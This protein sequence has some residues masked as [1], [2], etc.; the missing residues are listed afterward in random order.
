M[1]DGAGR[2]WWLEAAADGGRAAAPQ[3]PRQRPATGPRLAV[4]ILLL[5]AV[6][7]TLMCFAL[8]AGA[9]L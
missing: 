8:E 3:S 9:M 1:S 6:V 7:S 2:A 5:G 4:A